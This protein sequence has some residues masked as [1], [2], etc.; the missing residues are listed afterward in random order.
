MCL[1]VDLC[2]TFAVTTCRVGAGAARV[3]A[4]VGL[5]RTTIPIVCFNETIKVLQTLESLTDYLYA[6]IYML[7]NIYVLHYF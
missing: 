1:F 4:L 3:I 2:S 6:Q 5:A 7:N